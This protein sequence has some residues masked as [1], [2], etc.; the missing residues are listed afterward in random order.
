MGRGAT[1]ALT[2]GETAQTVHA[3]V[4]AT[5]ARGRDPAVVPAGASVVS[6]PVPVTT[7]LPA[8]REDGGT[9]RRIEP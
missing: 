4:W 2:T 3:A 7:D 1:L 8:L 9:D 6:P 5:D